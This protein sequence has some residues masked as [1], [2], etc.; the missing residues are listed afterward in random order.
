MGARPTLSPAQIVEACDMRERGWS[1]TRISRW[2]GARGVSVS[3][4]A[5]N[6]TCLTNGADLPASLRVPHRRPP[7]GTAIMRAG[8]VLRTFSLAEDRRLR[9]LEAEGLTMSEIA[10]AMDRKPNS[11]RGRLA[12]LA[13]YDARAE[14]SS[15]EAV[16]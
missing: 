4:S 12:R 11:I 1:A 10:R 8:R 9:A 14:E 16:A 13:R 3:A 5:I 15:R 2:F 6:D 7:P